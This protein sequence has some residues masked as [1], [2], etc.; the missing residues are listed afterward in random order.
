MGVIKTPAQLH[1]LA[2]SGKILATGVM[3]T[4]AA[5]KPGVS[6][7]ELNEL[8][9]TTIRALGAEPSFLGYKEY[10]KSICTSINDE[11]V[12]AIPGKRIL[13][14]GDII[15]VDC[16]VRYKGMCTDMARTVGVGTL[17][18]NTQ[19]LLDVTEE[20]MKLG[21]AQ[22]VPGNTIGDIG[23]AIQNYVESRGYS[24]VRVLVGHGVGTKVHEEPQVPNYGRKGEGMKLESGMALA[25][26]PMVNMGTAEVIFEKDGWTVRTTDGTLSAHFEDTVIITEN[27]PQVV[28]TL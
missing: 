17:S 18:A 6:T 14:E 5:V 1:A 11:V 3:A 24:V 27:G 9:D 20:A 21:I 8:F 16:G 2:E 19:R 25:I 26:E 22:L 13:Q 12:H 4:V 7:D 15:G 23:A 28:T 10:P